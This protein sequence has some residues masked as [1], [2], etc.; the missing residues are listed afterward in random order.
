MDNAPW[1]AT[2]GRQANKAWLAGAIVAV[3][4]IPQTRELI[5]QAFDA[6]GVSPTL[7]GFLF[8]LIGYAVV[9]AKANR[10]GAS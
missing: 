3:A 9:W 5:Q 7:A 1:Y 8:A 6:V 2:L 10:G 4:A